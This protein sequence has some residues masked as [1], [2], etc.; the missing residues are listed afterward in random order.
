MVAAT[1]TDNDRV[2]AVAIFDALGP[3][4]AQRIT[5]WSAKTITAWAR[6]EVYR[7]HAPATPDFTEEDWATQLAKTLK[8]VSLVAATRELSLAPQAEGVLANK[9]RTTAVHDIQLLEGKATERT[10][11]VDATE[12]EALALMDAIQSRKAK[13]ALSD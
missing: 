11:S 5:G 6:K 1:P 12:Q 13:A 3:D 8:A 2:A 7:T 10:E 9:I 4:E